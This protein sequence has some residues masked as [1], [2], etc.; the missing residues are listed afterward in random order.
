MTRKQHLLTALNV[1]M[2]DFSWCF[3][4]IC[5]VLACFALSSAHEHTHGHSHDV[6]SFKYSKEANDA[7][8]GDNSILEDRQNYSDYTWLYAL[9]STALISAAPIVILFFIPLDNS[10]AHQP[11]LK[12]L[13]S[14]ASGGLL[15]DAF[16]HLIPHAIMAQDSGAEDG[17]AHSHSHGHSHDSHDGSHTHDLS[18]GL[19]VLG[20]IVAFLMVEKFV[21]YVKGGSHGH[22]HSKPAPKAEMKGDEK[23]DDAKK[24][25]EKISEPGKV[26]LQENYWLMKSIFIFFKCSS[27]RN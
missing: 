11:R 17:H 27:R 13:L 24:A 7:E 5:L 26:L 14:F 12:V 9:G 6:P 21:R 22:S 20:G 3:T 1:N 15:G 10:D 25:T 18:V 4:K 19:W 8:L 16:L 23:P 2:N